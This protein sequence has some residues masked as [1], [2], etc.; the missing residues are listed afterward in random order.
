LGSADGSFKDRLGAL[1]K[2]LAAL[3]DE[4]HLELPPGS[5]GLRQT[6]VRLPDVHSYYTPPMR[7]APFNPDNVIL[8]TLQP[9]ELIALR[10]VVMQDVTQ[11]FSPEKVNRKV[12]GLFNGHSRVNV[13]ELPQELLNDLHWLTTIIAYAHHPEVSYG[14]VAVE[15]EPVRVGPYRV[16]SFDLIKNTDG[17]RK[18]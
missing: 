8:P 5:P 10:A 1:A 15:G 14:L 12:S 3:S 7:R 18:E 6:P 16:A 4:G 9:D 11:A 13:A 2:L 17:R